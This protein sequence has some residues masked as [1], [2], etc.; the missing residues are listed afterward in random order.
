MISTAASMSIPSGTPPKDDIRSVYDRLA[1][2]AS[3]DLIYGYSAT[4]Y[5]VSVPGA[6]PQRSPPCVVSNASARKGQMIQ[7]STKR[8]KVPS[9]YPLRR[10]SPTSSAP[11]TSISVRGPDTSILEA[12]HDQDRDRKG[13]HYLYQVRTPPP[14][15]SSPTLLL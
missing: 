7:A 3:V 15:L 4:R 1:G 10:V 11:F 8:Y 6:P 9:C 12:S 14:F 5:F 2:G 13:H